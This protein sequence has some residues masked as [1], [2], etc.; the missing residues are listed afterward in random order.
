MGI[1]KSI[2]FKDKELLDKLEAEAVE[3]GRSLSSHVS[4]L[5]RRET[6]SNNTEKG[7]FGPGEKLQEGGED[8]SLSEMNKP[9]IA[10]MKGSGLLKAASSISTKSP[11]FK[12][13]VPKTGKKGGKQ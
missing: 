5:C 9:T 4:F 6:F 12:G 1:I 2:H 8:Q 13:G 10:E 7:T 11:E 3:M